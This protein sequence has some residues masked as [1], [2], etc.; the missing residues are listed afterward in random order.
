MIKS[1]VMGWKGVKKGGRD[2]SPYLIKVNVVVSSLLMEFIICTTYS[3]FH[4]FDQQLDF[5]IEK[6]Q[7]NVHL[8][9]WIELKFKMFQRYHS[10]HQYAILQYSD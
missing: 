3:A 8:R 5:K 2:I 1:Y 7:N 4:P 6:G 10:I 9:E